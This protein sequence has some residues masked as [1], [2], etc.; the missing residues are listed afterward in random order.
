M[1]KTLLRVRLAGLLAWFTGAG[2]RK[3]AVSRWKMTGFALLMLYAL[4]ALLFYFYFLFS[5]LAAPFAAAGLGWVYFALFAVVAFALM[6]IGSVFTA[7]AQ[8]FEARDNELLLALPIPSGKI[9]LSRMV[10]LFLLDLLL[11]LLAALPAALAWYRSGGWGAGGLACFFLLLAA[12]ALFTLAVSALFAWLLSLLTARLRRKSLFTTLF[13]LLFFALYFYAVQQANQFVLDLA[14][15]GETL[16]AELGAVAPLYWAG[17]AMAEGAPGPLLKALLCLLPPFVLAYVLLARTFLRTAA[18]HGAVGKVRYREKALRVSGLSRALYRR[19]LSRFLSSSVYVVNSGLGA[20][21]TLV[22]AAAIVWKRAELLALTAALPEEL[23]AYPVPLVVL[24]LCLCGGMTT[25][26]AASVSIEGRS[27]WVLR[28]LPVPEKAALTAKLRVHLTV[29]LPPVLLAELAAAL[30][31]RPGGLLLA[32]LLLIPAVF[33]VVMALLGL[34]LDLRGAR[35][36]WLSE[37]QAVK[38]NLSVVF[39]MFIGWG[40]CLL[41]LIP[42]L[43]LSLPARGLALLLLG[44]LALLAALAAGLCRLL[45][46]WGC[47]RLAE[48]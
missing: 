6:F 16:A 30:V 12:L 17:R 19:E 3:K 28:S 26:S 48:L 40:L 21:F 4:G 11:G 13:S 43:L 15:R 18:S 1:V 36:D 31:F 2:R 44:W 14:A 47:A 29:G 10:F 25:I 27:L 32:A 24:A 34:L 8:L 45:Y 37:T 42:A 35:F 22:A 7:K 41:P 38:S 20:L 5:T 33:A 46:T 9:L 23:A 39:T